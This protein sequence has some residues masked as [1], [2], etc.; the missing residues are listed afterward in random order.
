[1][2]RPKQNENWT[3]TKRE[4]YL[5]IEFI[6]GDDY[7]HTPKKKGKFKALRVGIGSNVNRYICEYVTGKKTIKDNTEYP[8]DIGYVQKKLFKHFFPIT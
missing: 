2:K 3:K 8:F 5:D 6:H 7:Q 4:D 1:L